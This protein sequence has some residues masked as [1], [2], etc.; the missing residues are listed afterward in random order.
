MVVHPLHTRSPLGSDTD[1]ILLLSIANH[2]ELLTE[3]VRAGLA[4]ASTER[5]LV[6][7]RP[8]EVTRL[9]ITDAG[10]RALTKLRWP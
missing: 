10:R 5:M 6:S 8:M 7:G 4:N 1:C 3:L 2:A 9:W